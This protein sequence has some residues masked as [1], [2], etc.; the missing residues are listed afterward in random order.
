[1]KSRSEPIELEASWSGAS[2]DS[3]GM[4]SSIS[5]MFLQRAAHTSAHVR[6]QVRRPPCKHQLRVTRI[7]HVY[8][9]GAR[10]NLAGRATLALMP[11]ARRRGRCG[12][13]AQLVGGKLVSRAVCPV[14]ER[15]DSAALPSFET[16]KADH[17]KDDD[18]D[19]DEGCLSRRQHSQ[20]RVGEFHVGHAPIFA[21]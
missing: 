9:Q 8:R 20:S 7:L 14:R 17:N 2:S 13:P 21:R 15:R 5:L 6:C 1:M 12:A 18:G 16:R 3:V 4:G 10:G 19:C 11:P